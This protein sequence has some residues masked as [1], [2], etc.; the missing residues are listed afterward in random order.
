MG[1]LVPGETLSLGGAGSATANPAHKGGLHL[2]PTATVTSSRVERLTTPVRVYNFEVADW[3]TYHVGDASGWVW[4]HNRCDPK[5]A[6]ARLKA[7]RK[8]NRALGLVQDHHLIPHAGSANFQNHGLVK[9]AN[10]NLKSYNRNI[11]ALGNHSGGHSKAYRDGVKEILDAQRDLFLQ[12]GGKNA[13]QFLDDAIAQIEQS[14][15]NGRLRP[16]TNKDVWT[17]R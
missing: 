3:H 13:Q 12:S 14:I 7:M 9:A 1:E 11:L 16:Y 6:I 2:G 8:Q 4:V 15:K 5:E 17:L 10:V